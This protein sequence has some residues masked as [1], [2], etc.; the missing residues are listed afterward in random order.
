[1]S[2]IFHIIARIVHTHLHSL[3]RNSVPKDSN[4][5]SQAPA[6]EHAHHTRPQLESVPAGMQHTVVHGR[7]ACEKGWLQMICG[8]SWMPLLG[9]GLYFILH[10]GVFEHRMAWK[11]VRLK[12][13]ATIRFLQPLLKWKVTND[14]TDQARGKMRWMPKTGG[15]WRPRMWPD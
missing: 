8:G 1:M 9:N 2:T 13:E 4:S 12:Q 11:K 5:E 7:R 15:S 3:H 14:N 10:W 6:W